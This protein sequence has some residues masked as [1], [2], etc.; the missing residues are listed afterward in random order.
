ML[1]RPLGIDAA[2]LTLRE[3]EVNPLVEA[4]SRMPYCTS[5]ARSVFS[6]SAVLDWLGLEHVGNLISNRGGMHH[7]Q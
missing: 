3:T 7:Q 6:S 2:Q 5:N 1:T 4:V